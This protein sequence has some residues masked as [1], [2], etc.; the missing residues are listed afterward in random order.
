[1]KVKP[2]VK[3]VGGKTQ[4]IEKLVENFP[5][6][7]NNYHEL[8]L[9]GSSVFLELHS[10]NLLLHKTVF[11][12]DINSS[13]VNLYNVILYKKPELI[14]ELDKDIY[15]NTRKFYYENRERFNDIKNED[16]VENA[17]LFLYLNKT[18]FNGMYREN[19][20]GKFNVPIGKS[21]SLPSVS[22]TSVLLNFNNALNTYSEKLFLTSKNCFDIS[23]LENFK[24]N[25]FVYLDPPYDD[26]FTNYTKYKFDK[27]VQIKLRDLFVLLCSKKCKV[28]L[29]NSDTEFIRKIYSHLPNI[30]II[31]INVKRLVNSKSQDRKIVKTELL[32][33]NY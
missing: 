23:L 25:D 26:T 15:S 19:N 17:A 7:F 14:N 24:E 10:R 29:S 33:V 18:C 8:F 4:I 27:E 21:K 30:K 6:S 12:N 28:A 32:I 22:D 16:T 31:T 3:W 13:L 1:M 5:D 11:L 9:G 20:S 2:V